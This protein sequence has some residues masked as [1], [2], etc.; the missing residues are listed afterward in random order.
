[1]IH[2]TITAILPNYN[3]ADFFVSRLEEVLSQTY[4]VSE[5]IVLDDASTDDSKKIIK[6]ELKNQEKLHKDIKF[7][8]SPNSTN[9]GN[10]FSQWEKG[11]ELATSDYI[12][13]AELDDLCTV[14]FLETTINPILKNE[15]IVLS[16]TNSKLVGDVSLRDK[17]RQK[18]DFIRKRHFPGKYSI[19]GKRELNKNLAV[20]NS[21]PNVSACIFKNLPELPRFLEGA[22]HYKLCGD[23]YFYTKLVEKEKI[24]YSSKKLNLH[25]LSKDSV[26]S[27]TSLERRFKEI[28]R[29]HSEVVLANN[30]HNS[31]LRRIERIEKKLKK[32]WKL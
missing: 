24:A 17:L 23:W 3:Y 32:R 15:K 12:W 22:K 21:I 5:I 29:V 14:D 31:T 20:F 18:F 26:T 9:S 16:Y 10:V 11:I 8:F 1:M 30:L 7:I 4:Q 25:R 6:Q 2:P 13:I 27:Q 28:K 19:S